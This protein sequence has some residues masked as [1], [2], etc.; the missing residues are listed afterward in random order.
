MLKPTLT[1]PSGFGNFLINAKVS[2]DLTTFDGLTVSGCHLPVPPVV[3]TTGQ[4]IASIAGPWKGTLTSVSGSSATISITIIEVGPD[5][6][7]FPSLSGKVTFSNSPCFK[8]GTL[9]GNQ[10]GTRF[11]GLINTSNGTIHIPQ[12]G[13][14]GSFLDLNNQ[15]AMS[16]SVEGGTC[17]GDYVSG[18]LVRQ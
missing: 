4:Q 8:S 13:G 15:L 14:P 6:T 18:T 16:Y 2:T 5:A 17:N 7:G 3:T 9:A 10:I 11:S 12:V 1:L